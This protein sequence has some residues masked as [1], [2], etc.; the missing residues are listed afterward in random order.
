MWEHRFG[1][2]RQRFRLKWDATR[3]FSR[4]R[5]CAECI[6]RCSDTTAKLQLIMW[7]KTSILPC[8]PLT[9][10]LFLCPSFPYTLSLPASFLSV[11][12]LPLLCCFLMASTQWDAPCDCGLCPDVHR[13]EETRWGHSRVPGSPCVSAVL[14]LAPAPF[15][16]NSLFPPPSYP[17]LLSTFLSFAHPPGSD[18]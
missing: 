15:Q 12:V 6:L 2:S 18:N 13:C 17:A 10:C 3:I 4:T 5:Y 1:R 9:I 11:C 14:S 7:G 8:W 16:E